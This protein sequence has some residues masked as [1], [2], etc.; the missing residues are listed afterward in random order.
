MQEL[1]DKERRDLTLDDRH[2]VDVMP[3]HTDKVVMRRGDN[4]WD[5]LWLSSSLLGLKEVVA[6]GAA[7]HTFPVLLQENIPWSVN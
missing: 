2:K 3:E 6:H 7:D 5:I 1:D 4:W